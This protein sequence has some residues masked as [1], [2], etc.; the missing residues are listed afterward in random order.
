M[1]PLLPNTGRLAGVFSFLGKAPAMK[2]LLLLTLLLLGPALADEAPL[3]HWTTWE[4]AFDRAKS[5][6]KLVLL[7]LEAVWCHWCHVMDKTTYRDPKVVSLLRETTV[8]VKVDQDS[9]PDLANRYQDYGWPATIIFDSQGRELARLSGYVKPER[10]VDI[11]ERLQKNPE[12][13]KDGPQSQAAQ[14]DSTKSAGLLAKLERRHIDLY[15]EE[16]GGWGRIHKFVNPPVVEYCLLRSLEGDEQNRAM[17]IQTLDANLAL[18]DPE[19]GGV[20][21]YSDSGV[22]NSPHYE[23]IM[24]TQAGNLKVYSL[25]YSQFGYPRYLKAAEQIAEYLMDELSAPDDGFYASQDADLVQGTKAKNYFALSS[26]AREALGVPRID[27][28]EYARECG[29]AVEALSLY[30]VVSGDAGALDRAVSAAAWALEERQVEGGGFRHGEGADPN[31]YLGDTLYMGRA[32]LMLYRVHSN[33]KWL[34]Q[35][36]WC[37]DFVAQN[38]DKERADGYY[39]SSQKDV[40][41]RAEN[42]DLARFAH[43]LYAHTGEPRYER[44]AKRAMRYFTIDGVT[45]YFNPGGILLA[46]AELKDDSPHITVVLQKHSE[47]ADEL[48]WAAASSPVGS[49]RLDRWHVDEP[50][51]PHSEV[52]Y[53]A[54]GDHAAYIC[55]KGRCTAPVTKPQDIQEFW[56]S[57]Y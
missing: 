7:D 2:K 36:R 1:R 26:S 19:W 35:A 56:R 27:K 24:K 9:R 34:E 52:K 38:F 10:M 40:R 33:P 54:F 49:L 47:K 30:A 55:T 11:L 25:A 8:A 50:L 15:D 44:M 5:E 43:L 41:D 53:P 37:G 42:I 17:A 18:I 4:G 6:N 20:Y 21:Q 45:D 46:A 48:F 32:F 57:D 28:S 13:L 14:G 3:V 51:P 23:K 16:R 12:P 29:Q 39:T 31:F 22:W